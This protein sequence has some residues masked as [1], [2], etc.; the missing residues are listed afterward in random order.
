[1]P[2]H[3]KTRLL[4]ALNI[5]ILL[6]SASG[7]GMS[8]MPDSVPSPPVEAP[9]SL[10]PSALS[11]HATET[12]SVEEHPLFNPARTPIKEKQASET[13]DRAVQ[14][15]PTL[16]GIVRGSK[17]IAGAILEELQSGSRKFVRQGESFQDW[18]VTAVYAKKIR[19]RRGP[20][21]IEL[22]L[23]FDPRSLTKSGS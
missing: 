14:P 10:R 6:A 5:A 4:L 18:T 15:P 23:S 21:E 20:Q 1:M 2:L 22:P 13:G 7:G 19:I 3:T 16:I 9:D 8:L 17:T 12:A 11:R